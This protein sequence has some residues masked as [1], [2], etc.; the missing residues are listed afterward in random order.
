[1]GY[2]E[3]KAQRSIFRL[4]FHSEMENLK[5]T[6]SYVMVLG[7]QTGV[8]I[9]LTKLPFDQLIFLQVSRNSTPF[10]LSL[11]KSYRTQ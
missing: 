3:A 8:L 9:I 10:S 7:N 4:F 5:V 1:M 6:I 2:F 11:R